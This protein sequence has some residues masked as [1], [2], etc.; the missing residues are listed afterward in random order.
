MQTDR[1]NPPSQSFRISNNPP[2]NTFGKG[3]TNRN[4]NN[5]S[6][7]V[8]RGN[9]D[10]NNEDKM[11]LRQQF[12]SSNVPY[13]PLQTPPRLRAL[14]GAYD[15]PKAYNTTSNDPYSNINPLPSIRSPYQSSRDGN[16][17]FPNLE[18]WGIT[19]QAALYDDPNVYRYNPSPLLPMYSLLNHST[20][21][22]NKKQKVR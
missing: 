15:F 4:N 9:T 11:M 17:N 20:N 13:S 19:N 10:K 5:N 12:R 18:S 7:V 3:A 14:N 16:A 8:K 1:T 6:N 21:K 2:T 22:K